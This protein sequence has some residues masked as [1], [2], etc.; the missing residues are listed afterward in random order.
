[1]FC[2]VVERKG[3]EPLTNGNIGE[4]FSQTKKLY[5]IHTDK[6]MDRR[7]CD[8]ING[9]NKIVDS[10]SR[11]RNEQSDAHGVGSSRINIEDY[12]ARLVVNAAANV[13]DFILSVA[14][15]AGSTKA[16]K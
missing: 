15:R 10:I 13:A 5:N 16:D 3:E 4:L 7:I 1:M 9:L 8:L 14:N 12:H 6:T 2:R 11:M